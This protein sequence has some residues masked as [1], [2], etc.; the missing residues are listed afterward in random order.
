MD[1]IFLGSISVGKVTFWKGLAPVF[2]SWMDLASYKS[3]M[4]SSAFHGTL[5]RSSKDKYYVAG[6][7]AKAD[8]T[9]QIIPTLVTPANGYNYTG[10]VIDIAA[11]GSNS[12]YIIATTEG[13]WIWG[14][15]NTNFILPGT[16][17]A[18][19]SPFQKVALPA[20]ID[21]KNIKSISAST[22]NFLILLQD[23]TVYAYAKSIAALN[24]AG[25]S[26]ATGGF[27]KVLL[28]ENVPLINISQ[29]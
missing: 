7:Y 11:V 27:T 22:N 15:L 8:G 6:Q 29:V 25:L 12:C 1:L 4:M 3:K 9:D 28:G 5:F 13:I 23:G 16:T 14:Y 26:T 10:E 18:G 2:D 17:N 19:A 21:P 20:E 24:G